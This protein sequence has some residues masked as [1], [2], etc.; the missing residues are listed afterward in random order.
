M[1]EKIACEV[2][3]LSSSP[4]SYFGDFGM[5]HARASDKRV[6]IFSEKALREKTTWETYVSMGR[7]AKLSCN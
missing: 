2:N 4:P 5:Q 3:N 1:A 6:Q 7:N